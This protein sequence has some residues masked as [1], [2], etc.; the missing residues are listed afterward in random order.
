MRARLILILLTVFAILSGYSN[1]IKL[2]ISPLKYSKGNEISFHQS[3]PLELYQITCCLDNGEGNDENE[4]Q[5]EQSSKKREFRSENFLNNI[6]LPILNLCADA[7]PALLLEVKNYSF[8]T[9]PRYLL[10]GVLRI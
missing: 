7:M 10:L 1:G 2:P 4:D 5:D 6:Q 9:I 8:L 3:L